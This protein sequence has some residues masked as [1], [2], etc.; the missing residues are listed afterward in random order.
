[1]TAIPVNP[2][3]SRA[4]RNAKRLAAASVRS[5][6]AESERTSREARRRRAGSEGQQRLPRLGRGG[7]QA[8]RQ[9]RRIVTFQHARRARRGVAMAGVGQRAEKRL[10]LLPRDTAGPEQYRFGA[11]DIEHRGFDADRAGAAV[12]HRRNA[13][14]ELLHDM[15][16]GSGA[17]VTGAVGTGAGNRP[18]GLPQQLQRQG[19][20][21]HPDCESVQACACQKR[22]R[23]VAGPRQHQAQR[24]RPEPL[25][26]ALRPGVNVDE[27]PREGNVGHVNDQRIESRPSLRGEDPGDGAVVGGIAAE[28]VDGLGGEGDEL[29]R[30]QQPCGL[31][32]LVGS[33][34]AGHGRTPTPRA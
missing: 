28:A 29:A 24:S 20:G 10:Q 26:H 17:H 30:S 31:V 34:Q 9:P 32:D 13:A 22:D 21:R 14:G 18:S 12:E 5:P 11:A 27:A 33:E 23:A 8:E 25:D 19:M 15:G 16:R 6:L 1:M 4:R 7:H 2:G 3:R